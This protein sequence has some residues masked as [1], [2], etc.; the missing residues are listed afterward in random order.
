MLSTLKELFD[1]FLAPLSEPSAGEQESALQLASAVLLLEVMRA[2]P[3]ARPIERQAV[4]AALQQ[5]FALQDEALAQLLRQAEQTVENAYDF[6]HFTASLNAH[7]TQAQKEHLVECMWRVAYADA[8]LDAHENHVISKLAGLL[9]VTHGAY[10]AAK[11][12]AK[13]AAG[14]LWP[15]GHPA[16]NGRTPTV[17]NAA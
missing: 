5:E 10:I 17:T 2:E 14:L 7:C 6:Q 12:R 1:S 13:E 8:H 4:Q 15:A 3:S 9:H 16:R 11:M